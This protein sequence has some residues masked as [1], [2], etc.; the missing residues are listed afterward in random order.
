[1]LSAGY[2]CDRPLAQVVFNHGNS[3]DLFSLSF[4]PLASRS[5]VELSAKTHSSR[6]TCARMPN[7]NQHL[8]IPALTRRAQTRL[9]YSSPS[10][11]V[12]AHSFRTCPR[13]PTTS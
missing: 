12:S 3:L 1:M 13:L 8:L 11:S 6:S 10:K 5:I 4:S 7:G 9:P 2:T